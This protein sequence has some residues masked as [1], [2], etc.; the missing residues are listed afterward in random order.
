MGKSSPDRRKDVSK[1]MIYI[2]DNFLRRI[3]YLM[4]AIDNHIY[5]F[6]CRVPKYGFSNFWT[7]TL[8]NGPMTSCSS[9]WSMRFSS[10]LIR[11]IAGHFWWW[12]ITRYSHLWLANLIAQRYLLLWCSLIKL[13]IQWWIGGWSKP[14][15]QILFYSNLNVIESPNMP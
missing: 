4:I 14:V 11:N 8:S 5:L 13:Y 3:I 15:Y 6:R 1:N 7:I 10:P 9:N 2:R 12:S